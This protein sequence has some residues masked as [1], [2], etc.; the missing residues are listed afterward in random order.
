MVNVFTVHL[1]I[2]K[3]A[4][5]FVVRDILWYKLSKYGVKGKLLKLIQSMYDN[6]KSKVKV[7]NNLSEDFVCLLGVQQGKCL[8]P[9]LFCMYLNDL[10]ETL[11]LNGVEGI[12]IDI[13]MKL[14][15]L[16]YADDI[17]LFSKTAEDLQHSL[18]VLSVYCTKWK[19]T[20]NVQKT[21]NGL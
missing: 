16:L 15:I 18:N 4:F 8:S 14:C 6:V 20:V 12:V 11:I 2:F 17:V 21:K 13:N 7:S 1:L 10:E 5:D 3:R 9:F 19:L